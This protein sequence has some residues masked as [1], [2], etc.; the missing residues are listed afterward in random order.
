MKDQHLKQRIADARTRA[1]LARMRFSNAL[2]TTI[3]RVDPERLADDARVAA[4]D[5]LDNL[6]QKLRVRLRNWPYI[7]APLIAGVALLMF[8]RPARLLARYAARAGTLAWTYR[9]LWRPK[10][11]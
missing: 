6:K 10:H 2:D 4:R 9:S 8:W 11:D 5:Q 3:H 1:D 7:V